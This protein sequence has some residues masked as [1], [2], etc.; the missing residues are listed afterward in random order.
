MRLFNARRVE[1]MST[2]REWSPFIKSNNLE[3]YLR[4]FDYNFTEDNIWKPLIDVSQDE[5]SIYIDVELSGITQ[6][7]I[8]LI[9]EDDQLI[10]KGE[11]KF[12]RKQDVKYDRVERFYGSFTRSFTLPDSANSNDI[13]ASFEKGLLTIKIGK[14]IYEAPKEIEIKIK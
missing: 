6:E 10:L 4:L 1:L 7:D 14:K 8:K 3:R 12:E 5:K 11:R 9:T 2:I 13:E